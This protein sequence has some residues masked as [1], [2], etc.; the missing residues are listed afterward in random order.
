MTTL[1]DRLA[2]IEA[3]IGALQ[4]AN[5]QQEE[6]AHSAVMLLKQARTHVQRL[7]GN[8]V[9][10]PPSAFTFGGPALRKGVDRD[11][12]KLLPPFAAKV[13]ALFRAM[14]GRGH[15]PLC[16]EAFRSPERAQHLSD[17]GAG[18]KLSMHC[19]GAAV[20]IVDEHAYWSAGQDFWDALGE[21]A[22]TLGLVWGG[23]WTRRDLPHVQ[24][25]AV[26]DQARFRAMTEAERIA[27]LTA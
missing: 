7:A 6:H 1:A 21:E 24:A 9:A 12:A 11:P 10:A 4:V 19:L 20:D 16:W 5:P 18:I 13:E 15:E 22:E 23:R 17:T 25:V 3:E 26:K 8:L 27:F 14:R 2:E